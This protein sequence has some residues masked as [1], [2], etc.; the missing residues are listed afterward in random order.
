MSIKNNWKKEHSTTE[1]AFDATL[2]LLFGEKR[3]GADKVREDV[4]RGFQEEAGNPYINVIEGKGRASFTPSFMNYFIN[5]TFPGLGHLVGEEASD[6]FK[7]QPDTLNV[8]TESSHRE[9][10]W[11]WDK[12]GGLLDDIIAEYT[13]AMDSKQK[14]SKT[15]FQKIYGASKEGLENMFLRILPNLFGYGEKIYDVEGTFEHE[16]HSVLEPKLKKQ[17]EDALNSYVENLWSKKHERAI[18]ENK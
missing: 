7:S 13:H 14:H 9:P 2:A 12:G 8:Y 11:M 17:Y 10:G 4:L 18:A 6:F 1:E 3:A 16:A 5:Q 15:D